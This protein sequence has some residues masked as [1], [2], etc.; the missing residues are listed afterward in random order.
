MKSGREVLRQLLLT[1]P[2]VLGGIDIVAE[3]GGIDQAVGVAAKSIP[4]EGFAAPIAVG[5]GG[6]EEGDADIARRLQETDA[7]LVGLRGFGPPGGGNRPDAEANFGQ[8]QV[9]V[10]ESAKLHG[11]NWVVG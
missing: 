1:A 8:A 3:L 10:G 7:L 9:G 6:I 5:V 11:G 4:Q 2:L